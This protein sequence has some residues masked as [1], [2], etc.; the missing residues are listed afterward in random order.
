MAYPLQSDGPEF[1]EFYQR[2]YRSV[3]RIC[4]TYMK[5]QYDA[6]DCTEDT[7][8][9]AITAS[10]SF[11]NERH[12]HAWLSVTAINVCKDRLKH[13]WNRKVEP[14]E[15]HENVLQKEPDESTGVLDAVMR[16]PPKYKDVVYLYYYDGYQT[17]EI[18]RMLGRPAST[19]RNQLRDAR[20]KLK[21][22]LGGDRL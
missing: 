17:D 20:G 16:L 6:E 8:V 1:A 14:I 19:V 15:N 2:H 9:R 21:E 4:Y 3:Y 18:G 7:F 5:N 22:L 13:W 12:E 11:E 10:P